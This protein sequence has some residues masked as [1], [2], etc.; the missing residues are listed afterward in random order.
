MY[1]C[2][3]ELAYADR[4]SWNERTFDFTNYYKAADKKMRLK[5][6]CA[7]YDDLS[8][9]RVGKGFSN[10]VVGWAMHWRDSSATPYLGDTAG[11][12]RYSGADADYED[13]YFFGQRESKNGY[14]FW[15]PKPKF[16][17]WKIK[18]VFGGVWPRGD[19]KYQYIPADR[20][21]LLP[22]EHGNVASLGN[23]T[24]PTVHPFDPQLNQGK[25]ALNPLRAQAQLNNRPTHTAVDARGPYSP[26][27]PRLLLPIVLLFIF[28][29]LF[30]S[31]TIRPDRGRQNH[32]ESDEW[33]WRGRFLRQ[34][35]VRQGLYYGGDVARRCI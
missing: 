12:N 16:L 2:R 29:C 4:G 21:K 11:T 18:D 1:Q 25:I 10:T 22:L 19:G 3:V 28:L 9:Y 23:H 14:G 34:R 7:W 15:T 20:L 32:M 5:E 24:T 35:S 13:N 31:K 6:G 30:S 27:A 17:G 26:H 33:S 8:I